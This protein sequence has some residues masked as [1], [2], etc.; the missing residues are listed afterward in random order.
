[1]NDKP[2]L[3]MYGTI[4]LIGPISAGKSTVAQA[5]AEKLGIPR[6]SM[7]DLRW[8]YYNEIGYDEAEVSRI[9][10]SENGIA[11][12]LHYWKPFEAHAV[13]R[14][15]ADHQ[16]CIIDFGAGHSVYED[17][18]LFAR[19]QNALAPYLN[20]ILLLPSPDPDESIPIL[21]ARFTEL[22]QRETGTV[23]PELLKFNAYLTRHPSNQRL[24]KRVVYTKDRTPEETC[25]EIIE[26]LI[27]I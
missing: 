22:L 4:V 3:P 7:D 26:R 15:L 18:A 19:V 14:V 9:A 17:E 27:R 6:Y 13:E 2:S 24:A 23:D 11:D 20:V 8:A 21:N 5:L 16:D 25:A 1:M 10:H 12:V